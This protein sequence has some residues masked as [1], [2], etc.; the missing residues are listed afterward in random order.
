M[1]ITSRFEYSCLT[2]DCSCYIV[3]L[4]RRRENKS[5]QFTSALAGVDYVT[6]LQMLLILFS[7]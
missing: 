6:F 5:I 7:L 1:L 4:D 3:C 2:N